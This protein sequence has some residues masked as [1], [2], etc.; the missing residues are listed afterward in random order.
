MMLRVAVAKVLFNRHA[1]QLLN[2]EIDVCNEFID[3]YNKVKEMMSK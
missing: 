2:K 1:G 3:N